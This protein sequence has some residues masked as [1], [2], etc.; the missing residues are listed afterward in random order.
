MTTTALSNLTHC[1]CIVSRSAKAAADEVSKIKTALLALTKIV[2][3]DLMDRI[4]EITERLDKLEE[5]YQDALGELHEEWAALVAS[6]KE[7]DGRIKALEK[8]Q[9]V[10]V[11]EKPSPQLAV[12]TY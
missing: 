12:S 6:F 9:N 8:S 1:G 11:T 7:F 4:H 3:T 2:P 10:A 5:S